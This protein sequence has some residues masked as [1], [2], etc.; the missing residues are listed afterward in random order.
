MM[1]FLGNEEKVYILDKTEGNAAVID[2]HPAWGA[3]LDINTQQTQLMSVLTNTFCA[4]GMHLPNGSYATFG[5]NGAIGPGGNIGS[6][7]NSAGSGAYDAQ[8]QDYDGTK[9]IRILNPCTSADDF[10]SS[11]CQWFDNPAVLSMQK[12]RWY[13]AAEALGDG[14][15]ALIGGFVNGGYI[16]RNTPNTDPEY[17]GGAA[18]PTYEFYPSR[19]N[20]TVMQFM[21]DTSG[22]NSY[23][24]TY[25][26]PSGQMLIQA[27][28]STILW[29]PDTNT[30]T[31]LPAMPKGVARVYP[32]SGAVAM[33]PLTPANDW[34]PTVIFCGGS[35]MP[36][37]YWG[38]YSY[39]NYNTWTYPASTDCQRL[40]PEPQDGSSPVY[41]Q[42][43]DMLEGRTM[44]QFIALPDGTLLVINGG[45]N[46]TAGYAQATGQTPSFNLMPFGESL[47]SGPVGTPAIYNPN[48]PSGNRWSNAGLATSNIA[49]LYHSSAML[50]PDASV[51]I[52]GS[53]PNIDVNL[54][55]IFPTTYQAEI[56]YPPYFSATVRPEPTG[57]PSTLSYGGQYFDITVPASSYTGSA[58]DA[59]A[60]TTV[61]LSR[62]GFTTHA[63]NMGQRH[64]QLNNT[65]TVNSDGSYILHVA[66]VPPNPNILTPGPCLM[67]VVIDGIPS[68]GTMV[69]V[70][71]GQVET[72]PTSAVSV[73]PPS[74]LNS[75]AQGSGT[76]TQSN[77]TSSGS[78]TGVI[79]GAVVGAIAVIGVVGA[80]FGI[81]VARRR[82]AASR[83]Q[84]AAS[85]AMDTSTRGGFSGAAMAMGMHADGARHSNSSAFVPLQQDNPSMAWNASTTSLH[86]PYGDDYYGGPNGS[87]YDPYNSDAIGRSSTGQ[88]L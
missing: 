18:E 34:N 62:G 22:L 58:N 19:G 2:G 57:I 6:V 75:A 79:I 55:T 72:Q 43:D 12:Q 13:S 77:D 44:G 76:P 70:G 85:Y 82:R 83:Q 60:N 64:L 80:L 61:V 74:V 15:I 47:A 87:Q 16:N 7:V 63:M 4:S 24:H 56:F 1:M 71:S 21:I 35:D 29:D 23:A 50:L 8:Y 53:N 30:E 46:G 78:H 52:A 10:T 17:E 88:R 51:L 69:I 37:E 31:P 49:R 39:P 11:Q 81:F 3:V 32:A 84:P 73:L 41:V 28:V 27:N 36:D 48:M 20:A 65:Y 42:D 54:S 33:L 14:T 38:N 59:A 68:N 45:L 66:Q 9:S 5:G 25:L 40:T 26:M 86:S 67:F